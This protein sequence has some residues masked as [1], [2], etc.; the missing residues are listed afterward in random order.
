MLTLKLAVGKS[1]GWITLNGATVTTSTGKMQ[2][3][4]E[5]QRQSRQRKTDA[6]S[7]CG[8]DTGE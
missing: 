7:G 5:A 8:E 3:Q 6:Q 4:E 1:D 2:S